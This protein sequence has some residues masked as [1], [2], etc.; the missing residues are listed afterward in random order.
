M[1]TINYLPSENKALLF[2]TLLGCSFLYSCTNKEEENKSEVFLGSPRNAQLSAKFIPKNWIQKQLAVTGDTSKTES[3]NFSFLSS[4]SPNTPSVN[5]LIENLIKLEPDLSKNWILNAGI[6]DNI[7]FAS[8]YFKINNAKAIEE[9]LDAKKIYLKVQQKNITL[10]LVDNKA[11]EHNFIIYDKEHLLLIKTYGNEKESM[12]L[13][14]NCTYST[15][16]DY[17]TQFEAEFKNK[18]NDLDIRIKND[19]KISEYIQL[20]IL[21]D[22]TAGF[23]GFLSLNVKENSLDLS[24]NPLN[25]IPLLDS[26]FLK[27]SPIQEKKA[28][29]QANI[30][31]KNLISILSKYEYLDDVEYELNK[32]KLNFK[33]LRTICNGLVQVAYTGKIN[34][35]EKTITYVFDENF[36]QVKK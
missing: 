33:T 25:T 29:V 32:G 19:S 13:A 8:I 9:L 21:K 3:E 6:E 27:F 23:D 36:N 30:E 14:Q 10:L 2:L 20:P 34:T 12:K 7:K 35:P 22:L 18:K 16:D 26:V 11:K 24:L 28:S 1:N 17:I 4:I 31:L 5:K 15:K